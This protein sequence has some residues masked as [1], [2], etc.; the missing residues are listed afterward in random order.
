[1]R[2]QYDLRKTAASTAKANN[3]MESRKN[4]G[5]YYDLSL[6]EQA[7]IPEDDKQAIIRDFDNSV[8][9]SWFSQPMPTMIQLDKYAM[10]WIIGQTATNIYRIYRKDG[11]R[12]MVIVELRKCKFEKGY[13]KTYHD[14]MTVT[15]TWEAENHNRFDGDIEMEV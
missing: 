4:P 15:D 11:R 3:L 9:V 6:L 1:M 12:Q 5:V 8:G 14:T 2:K 13:H 7:N 10:K